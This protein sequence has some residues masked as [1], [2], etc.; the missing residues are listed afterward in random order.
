MDHDWMR[1][2]LEAFEALAT[3]YLGLKK[4]T[5]GR[6]LLSSGT[7]GVHPKAPVLRAEMYATEPTVK[8]ILACL[9]PELAEK[10]FV[11][12]S[13]DVTGARAQ[14][15]RG[16]GIL[17]DMDEW[18]TR[19]TPDAPSLPADQFH[20]WVW[21]AARTFWESKHFRAAVHAAASSIS[22]H[23]QD[24]LGRR[25]VADA[26]L[27]QEALS[28][29]APE[30]GKPRLRIPGDPTNPDVKTRQRGALLLGQGAYSALRNPAAHGVTDLPEQEALEQL[31]TFSVLARLIDEC[32][33]VT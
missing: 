21:D 11:N 26:A 33:V 20:P 8:K 10:F 25:D 2:R 3:E 31:A 1:Q 16:L 18:A 22:A 23:L 7:T 15:R 32:Q 4:P 19:L 14:V 17:A 13:G 29:N 30:P 28:S 12:H 27:V 6:T 9:D 5:V 24:K